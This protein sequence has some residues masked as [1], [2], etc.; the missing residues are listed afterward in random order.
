MS[1][2]KLFQIKIECVYTTDLKIK[3]LLKQL[4]I[5][6]NINFGELHLLSQVQQW[7]LLIFY[8]FALLT[9]FTNFD[10]TVCELCPRHGIKVT[11]SGLVL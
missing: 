3:Y 2:T 4:T 10:I 9:V 11:H 5:S 8:S 1:G 6:L 7:S